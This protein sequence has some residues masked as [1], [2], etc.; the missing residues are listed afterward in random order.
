M[1]FLR[2]IAYCNMQFFY[3]IACFIVQFRIFYY[4]CNGFIMF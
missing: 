2:E 1:Q 3:K 4:L